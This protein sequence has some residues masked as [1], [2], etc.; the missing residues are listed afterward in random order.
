M[1]QFSTTI[2]ILSSSIKISGKNL[3][4]LLQAVMPFSMNDLFLDN[5]KFY[6][7]FLKRKKI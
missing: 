2:L 6:V 5:G 3:E 7:I 1:R 4:R